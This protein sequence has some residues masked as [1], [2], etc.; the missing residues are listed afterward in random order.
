MNENLIGIYKTILVTV[1]V[2]TLSVKLAKML[3][4]IKVRHST[5]IAY[6]CRLK[7]SMDIQALIL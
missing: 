4:G 3:V 7:I 1:L 2:F 6:F 5:K